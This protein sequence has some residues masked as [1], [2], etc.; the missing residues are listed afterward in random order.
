MLLLP[1]IDII[2]VLI[3]MTFIIFLVIVFII[4]FFSHLLTFV[5]TCFEDLLPMM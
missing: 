1:F 5:H 3:L 2:Q 4:E